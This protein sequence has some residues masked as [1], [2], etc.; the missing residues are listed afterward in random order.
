MVIGSGGE[1]M[2]VMPFRQALE[3]AR[4]VGLDLVA[5][6][7][8]AVPPVC[9]LLDYGKYKY[10]QTKKEREAKKHQKASSVREIRF[11]PRIRGHDLEG[12]AQLALRLLAE[13][14][15]VKVSV[16]FRGREGTHPEIGWNH[17]KRL[18]ELVRDKAAIERPPALEGE[19]IV[20]FL[21]PAK[22]KAE[23]PA[24][25]KPVA[26]TPEVPASPEQSPAPQ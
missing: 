25:A 14:N 10:E 23:A 20:M 5:V 15:K 24:A 13:G 7:P 17:L 18:A 21:A 2:G 4:G 11:R 19:N 9:R 6:A 8:T 1:R 26:A 22:A 3:T 12:K 16:V